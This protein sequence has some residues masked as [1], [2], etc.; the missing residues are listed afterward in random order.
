[1]Y[2]PPGKAFSAAR[3]DWM[4]DRMID[5]GEFRRI[6]LMQVLLAVADAFAMNFVALHLVGLGYR[7]DQIILAA[8]IAFAVPAGLI[9]VMRRAR[10]RISFS[11]AFAAKI[12]AYLVVLFFL[13]PHTLKL[14]YISN[15]LVLVFFWI[16]YNL[17]FFSFATE[18]SR[19]YSGSIAIAVYPLAGLVI[20]P[21][22]GYTWSLHGFRMNVLVS[23]AI[24]IAAIIYMWLN[25]AIKLRRFDYR[26][27]ESLRRLRGYRSLF[28]LQ[29]LWEASSFM[30][31]PFLTLLLVR[32]ELKLGLFLSYLG[33]LSVVSTIMLSRLSDRRGSRTA[34]LYP[35]LLITGALT[36]CLVLARTFFWWVLLAG[37]VNFMGVLTTPFLIAVAL[38]AKVTGISMWTG[39]EL[40][41]NLG[42][43]AG[44][45]ILLAVYRYTSEPRLAFVFLGC[46]L[47]AYALVL[48]LKRIYPRMRIVPSQPAR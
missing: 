43:S 7:L 6:Y 29:G 4:G 44:G 48:H 22:A 23:V 5:S 45:G 38:D 8:M 15:A 35:A 30:G 27:S 20:P 47:F 41:L 19:A 24:L 16:P 11:I 28:F 2:I 26:I 18:K 42:R 12:A 1:M 33:A 37:A 10:A 36:V 13:N 17:E 9:A 14:I 21:L 46:S 31:I 32:T 34:F 39:R 25:K 40:L 3:E